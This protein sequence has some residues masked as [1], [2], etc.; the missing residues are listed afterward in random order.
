MLR[1]GLAIF[2]VLSA[3]IVVSEWL[4]RTTFF[5]HIGTS[6]L[7]IVVTAVVAN[8]GLLPTSAAQAPIYDGVF[9]IVAPLAIFLLLLNVNLREVIKAG[10]PMLLAFALGA[11]GTVAGVLL[12]MHLIDGAAVIGAPYRALGGMFTATY[13]GGSINF[14]SI[15]LHYG[16]A[17]EGTLFAGAV[18]VD[19]IIGTLWMVA[20]LA[21]PKLLAPA[22]STATASP[23]EAQA[24]IT[25]IDDDTEAVH[26]LDLGLLLGLAAFA[27]WVSNE[28]ATLSGLPSILILTTI[29]LVIA[30]F[31][32]VKKLRGTR[33]LGMFGIYLFLAVI[34]A[35]CDLRAL[36]EI[37][38]LGTALLVL[39]TTILVLHGLAT[40]GLGRFLRLDANV[41][42][43]ASQAC[44]GGPT[45]ALAVAR[46]LGRPD[47]L[48]PG[49]L[50]GSLG[51]AAGTY[52]GFWVAEFML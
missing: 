51:Y 3:T 37:G 8:L 14:N 13:I 50:A 16:V 6:L 17:E 30:Q 28:L 19:N 48:V 36:Q 4:V 2:A 39:T 49:I 38:A 22:V 35:F 1:D 52:I 24:F 33:L 29:A 5:R 15:A 20:C 47:L 12:G 34:G 7:V 41:V 42:A 23:A 10:G 26:P 45:S 31:R 27:T 32:A 44:F 11:A 18:A 46:S 9:T 43:V 40:F 25:G 21:L